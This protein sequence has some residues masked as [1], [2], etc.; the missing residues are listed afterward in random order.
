V[1]P[2][3]PPSLN[4][5]NSL[6]AQFDLELPATLIFDHPTPGNLAAFVAAELSR[7]NMHSVTGGSLALPASFPKVA[8]A[9]AARN[10]SLCQLQQQLTELVAEVAG[11]AVQ[12][13]QQPL[14]EAGV[15]SIDSVEIR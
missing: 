9:P 7:R 11:T 14:M 2:L 5:R 8:T 6:A 3:F 4:C 13:V 12:S 10:A 1:C 15:G